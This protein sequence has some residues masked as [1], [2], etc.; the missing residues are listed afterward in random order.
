MT[1]GSGETWLLYDG[2]CPFC[3]RYVAFTRLRETIGPVRLIDAREGGPEVEEAR[4]AGLVI[5]EGM[6]LKLD[7]TLYHGNACLN[8]L[9][10]LSSRSGLFNRLTYWSFRSPAV[11]RISYPVLKSGRA[12]ALRLLGRQGL[13]Y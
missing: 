4:A 10:L 8:R 6:V 5:D 12:L 1:S 11:A 13:G 7:G 9:A 2:E 3:A